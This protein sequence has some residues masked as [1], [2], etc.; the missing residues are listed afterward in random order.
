M[1]L[2]RRHLYNRRTIVSAAI[3]GIAAQCTQADTT[4][5]HFSNP[6]PAYP[7]P[8]PGNTAPDV[9]RDPNAVMP[10]ITPFIAP[11]TQ[12]SQ[13]GAASLAAPLTDAF[14]LTRRS[15]VL[16][17]GLGPALGTSGITAPALTLLHKKTDGT[18]ETVGTNTNWTTAVPQTDGP[19]VLESLFGQIGASTLSRTSKDAALYLQLDPGDYGVELGAGPTDGSAF[20]RFVA[21]SAVSVGPEGNVYV[22]D[23]GGIVTINS[24]STTSLVGSGLGKGASVLDQFGNLFYA[25]TTH[26][27]IRKISYSGVVT[28]V[29][30][31][32]DV[33]GFVDGDSATTALFN[34]PEGITRDKN[35][36]LYVADTGNSA[37]RVLALSGTDPNGPH[38]TVATLSL[39]QG[40]DITPTPTPAPTTSPTTAPTTTPPTPTPSTKPNN[41][42]GG[43]GG[44]GAFGLPF[45]ALLGLLAGLRSFLRR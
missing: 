45:L 39:T 44:G 7:T 11:F 25:D 5:W 41:Q 19:V 3:L 4:V 29:A 37:I 16:I 27:V 30:G 15:N 42:G 24:G 1:H 13:T 18:W 43:G 36:T 38:P 22:G 26:S 33:T 17:R 2:T 12:Q 23:N 32:P 34:H 8:A 21:P 20:Y 6:P 10:P 31:Q 14:T 28:V 35:G 40:I 9:T